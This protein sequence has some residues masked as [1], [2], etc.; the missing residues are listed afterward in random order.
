MAKKS[1]AILDLEKSAQEFLETTN[2]DDVAPLIN[3]EVEF[4]HIQLK[5]I[6]INEQVRSKEQ[7]D[8]ESIKDLIDS[9]TEK[10]VLQ[11]VIVY[12]SPDDMHKY[13]LLAGERRY[14]ASQASNRPHIPARIFPKKP[15]EAEII[16]IQLIENLQREGCTCAYR[17]VICRQ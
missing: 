12:K 7:M 8:N 9:V 11:P 3:T 2:V 10:G 4:S 1:K 5:D 13:I 17:P 16:E 15:S 14:M 6:I